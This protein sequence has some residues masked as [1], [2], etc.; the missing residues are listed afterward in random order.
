VNILVL[1][2]DYPVTTRMPGSSRLFNLCRQMARRHCLHLAFFRRSKQ[3]GVAFTDD[4][5]NRNV[6][7]DCTTLPSTE[8]LHL[9]EPTWLNRQFH[10][11]TFQP[12]Y[13]MRRLAPQRLARCRQIVG[14]LLQR[15]RIDLL[16]V[17]GA[18]MMEHVP[19]ACTI[20][21]VT[22]FCDCGSL[23]VSQSARDEKRPLRRLVRRFEATGMARWEKW[24]AEAADITIAVSGRDEEGIL[25]SCPSAR[26]MV[27]PNGIDSDFFAPRPREETGPG[28]GKLVFTGVMRYPP[29]ADAACHFAREV[30]PL[31]RQ[32]W[33][34][35]EFWIVGA[36]PPPAVTELSTMPGIKITGT[37]ADVRPY[38]YGSDV[39]V[40]PV[41][42]GTGVKNKLLAALAMKL[43]V[44]ATRDSLLGLRAIDG[45]HLLAADTPQEFAKHVSSLL[46]KGP[47]A[48]ALTENGRKLIEQHYS[49]RTYGAELEQALVGLVQ[50]KK[51]AM[52]DVAG[53]LPQRRSSC[54]ERVL[55]IA[56]TEAEVPNA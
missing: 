6:F 27:I 13:S 4:P 26:T 36:D 51:G 37:V 35:A 15:E 49:W 21:I 5:D 1:A 45:E 52:V 28:T 17:D 8:D 30:F 53:Q 33:P 22:D 29:N 25:R 16:Y 47:T 34:S 46:R 31:V 55:P 40:C 54:R 19:P 44:V 32:Q 20:P 48:N 39:F 50:D 2:W 38:L 23:L 42:Q 9:S 24:A 11:L 43:P 41:R 7:Q 10:R 18:S 14:E 56:A 12:Y 3:R